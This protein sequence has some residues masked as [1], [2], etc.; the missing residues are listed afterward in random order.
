MANWH[1]KEDWPN[2]KWPNGEHPEQFF[3][4]PQLL[5]DIK[6]LMDLTDYKEP[7]NIPTWASNF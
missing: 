7:P 5:T 6:A 4:V 2:G 1:L 3:M